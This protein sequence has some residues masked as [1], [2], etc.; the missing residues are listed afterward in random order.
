MINSINCIQ[1]FFELG[2]SIGKKL[3]KRYFTKEI[4]IGRFEKIFCALI[5]MEKFIAYTK[6]K[7]KFNRYLF[8]M[9]SIAML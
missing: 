4:I 6:W 2:V 9:K 5:W 7:N 1:L 3:L 8:A